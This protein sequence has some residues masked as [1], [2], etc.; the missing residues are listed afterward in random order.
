MLT[1]CTISFDIH[2]G[3][4]CREANHIT[5]MGF[6]CCVPGCKSG[7]ASDNSSNVSMFSFPSDEVRMKQW[8]RLIHRADFVPNK[9]SK[10]CSK[11]FIESDFIS[12]RHDSNASRK[13]SRGGII[14][15]CLN[16]NANPSVF[17]NQPS[18]FTSPPAP[19]RATTS[20]SESRL[21]KENAAIQDLIDQM[22]KQD[23][24]SSLSDIRD[25]SIG[26]VLPG[27]FF[28]RQPT[29]TSVCL[30]LSV[31]ESSSPPRL[32]ASIRVN[33]DLSFSAWSSD[34]LVSRDQLADTMK[35][36]SKIVS[37]CDLQNLM[38][39][40]NYKPEVDPVPSA[41]QLLEKYIASESPSEDMRKKLA[42]ICE[43]LSHLLKESKR[44]QYS[45]SALVSALIWH[46]HSSSCYRAI[47]NEGALTLPSER[48]L[49][50]LS[51]RFN[52]SSDTTVSYLKKRLSCLNEFQSTVSLIFDEVYVHQ[53][54]D[55]HQGRFSGLCDSNGAM[56]HTVLCFMINSL[57]GKFCDVVAM[58]ALDRLTVD[59]LTQCFLSALAVAMKAGFHVAVTICD[60]HI[61]NR[62]F[63][64]DY[65]CK[66]TL[67]ASAPNPHD[68]ST[69]IF[70]LLDPT[71]TMKNI[72][73]NFQ[74]KG[75]LSIPDTCGSNT[76]YEANFSHVRQLFEMESH[77]SLRMAHKLN[78]ACFNPSAIQRTSAKLTYSVFHESTV[79]A[80]EYYAAN[81]HEAWSGTARFMRFIHT[82]MTIINV[83]DSTVGIRKRD[84]NRKP[85]A[86]ITD[87]RLTLLENYGAFFQ[88]WKVSGCKGLTS[89]TRTACIS[90]CQ[91]LPQL[92][93]FLLRR[94]FAY[95]LL[96][97]VQSD[98][99]E[100]RFG[101]YRQMSG[102]NYFISVKQIVESEKK[103]KIV[104]FL[105]HSGMSPCDL[106]LVHDDEDSLS[107]SQ[108]WPLDFES[109]ETALEESELQIITFVAGYV[110]FQLAK[111]LNCQECEKWMT[112]SVA[113]PELHV[114]S[115]QHSDFL[116]MVSRGF[117]KSPSDSLFMLC[118]YAYCAFAFL[119]KSSEFSQFLMASSPKEIFTNS[120]N[121]MLKHSPRD[122]LVSYTCVTNS[123][124]KPVS[125]SLNTFFNVLASNFVKNAKKSSNNLAKQSK[126]KK[127]S[128]L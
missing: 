100:H 102:S 91:T 37:F 65:L 99:L 10:V 2:F 4:F 74:K 83:K 47:L 11:H 110:A 3:L 1:F 72:F 58:F 20:H 75:K 36:S 27:N 26:S 94:G 29:D 30:F 71:H 80:M 77:F 114:E 117:L 121:E 16:E 69:T 108:I 13:R 86:S 54:I 113:L 42:F 79:N 33:E 101:R 57:S 61:V 123:H 35:N 40:L 109:V 73:N 28:F 111:R 118:T 112:S 43:Q 38:S 96:G 126:I 34:G 41:I 89:E 81:G 88:E 87:K 103:I 7:Y 48:T 107:S 23:S 97:Q 93:R 125:S 49:R 8:L 19:P 56:A 53:T 31:D 22:E 44:P 32:L 90:M 122:D 39:F 124:H 50:R 95:V 76:T 51:N 25:K 14:L 115:D 128:S 78:S 85:I 15:R 52:I 18:Y 24:I 59:I 62:Q 119:K 17:P 105:K 63:L 70:I 60:N 45:P 82:I 106:S 104:S 67:S 116:E 84:E 55:Y 12:D 92:A 127:L 98:Q 66:G 5:D 46:S 64:T 68:P 21:L 9:N 120:V 6:K